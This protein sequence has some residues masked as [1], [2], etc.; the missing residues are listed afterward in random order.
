[1]HEIIDH[2]CN[3]CALNSKMNEKVKVVDKQ[4]T[5]HYV[6]LDSL[7]NSDEQAGYYLIHP[8]G[9]GERG[10]GEPK[11][12][13]HSSFGDN[14]IFFNQEIH[15][16]DSITN[17]ID[18]LNK[19]STHLLIVTDCSV[20]IPVI[21]QHIRAEDAKR[22]LF[23]EELNVNPSVKIIGEEF[24]KN[25]KLDSMLTD[26][27]KR[28]YYRLRDIRVHE[29]IMFFDAEIYD[30][31]STGTLIQALTEWESSILIVTN[32]KLNIS[33][34]FQYITGEDI[35]RLFL[36]EELA[37]NPTFGA[38]ARPHRKATNQ[39]KEQLSIYKLPKLL[40]K[41]VQRRW[42]NFAPGEVIAIERSTTNTYF[43]AVE[44]ITGIR[45]K[46]QK[47]LGSN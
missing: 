2:F 3:A 47:L 22:L 35:S 28:G 39:E 34:I 43:R 10:M 21:L 8:K 18:A 46:V 38:M 19:F 12:R 29:E 42:Y 15:N 5:P 44:E 25:V 16:E 40:I 32:Y 11:N 36:R 6:S 20:R 24:E 30:K 9:S 14:I 37:I 41:D 4:L 27:E 17:L 33:E 13:L 45:E 1:M 26:E 7:L 31:S 23:R